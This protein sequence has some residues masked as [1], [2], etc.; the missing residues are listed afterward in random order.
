MGPGVGREGKGGGVLISLLLQS[1]IPEYLITLRFLFTE[2][3]C[4]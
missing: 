4:D 2:L 3:M 1:V